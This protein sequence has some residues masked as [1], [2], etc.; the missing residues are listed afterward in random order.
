MVKRTIYIPEWLESEISNLS[1]RERRSFSAQ[2]LVM[3]ERSVVRHTS[4]YFNTW[5]PT[6]SEMSDPKNFSEDNDPS[7]L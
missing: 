5:L 3:L 1:Q 6:D 2:V 7:W 4:P